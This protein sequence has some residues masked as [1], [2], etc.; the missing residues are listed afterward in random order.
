MAFDT[1]TLVNRIEQKAALPE[2]RYTETEILDS[3][4]RT[5]LS[6]VVPVIRSVNQEEYVVST[7]VAI[8]SGTY[9]YNL[10]TRAQGQSLREV[11]LET[12]GVRRNLPYV[13]LETADV[14]QTGEPSYCYLENNKLVVWPTPNSSSGNLI[15]W[16]YRRPSTL[17]VDS[18]GFEVTAINGTVVTVSGSPSWSASQTLDTIDGNDG[19]NIDTMDNSYSSVSGSDITFATLPTDLAVGDY[20]CKSGETIFPQLPAEAHEMLVTYTAANLLFEMG[21]QG[22]GERLRADG[23]RLARAYTSIITPRITGARQ[24]YSTPLI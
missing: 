5:L 11:Q 6:E 23:D 19:Y 14:N 21:D 3:A 2:G 24:P 20:I 1:A 22:N 15:V 13:K 7:S 10:P 9:K 8:V 18:E 16:Y 12:G 4:Y 17:V